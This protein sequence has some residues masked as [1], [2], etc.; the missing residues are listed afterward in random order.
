[1]NNIIFEKSFYGKRAIINGVWDDSYIELMK[2]KNVDEIEL[3]DGKG[4][5]G[6]SV[7][8]LKHFPNLKSLIIID[9][10]IKSVD[11]IYY[12]TKLKKLE[13]VTYSKIPINFNIFSELEE[14]VFEWIKDSESLFE[15]VNLKTLFINNYSVKNDDSFSNLINLKEL[16]IYNSKIEKIEQI[17][18]LKNLEKLRIANLSKI[19]SL[20]GIDQLTNL[21]EL[22]IKKCKAISSVS[23]IFYLEKLRLLHLIDIGSILSIRGIENLSKL[24]DFMFYESTNVIDGDLTPI[25]K[26]KKLNKVSFQNRKHYTH[27]REIFY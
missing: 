25:T 4:W 17:S 7:T 26:L 11:S 13:L 10:K 14:C 23:E 24:E 22:E 9:L 19:K 16:T 5:N 3:N 18:K 27:K 15:L 20:K 1:M 2:E 6:N 21:E 12:L 8:F